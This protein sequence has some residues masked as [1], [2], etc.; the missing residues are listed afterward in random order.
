M[1][2]KPM[3]SYCG[4]MAGADW[5]FRHEPCSVAVELPV[6]LHIESVGDHVIFCSPCELDA[7]VVGFLFMAG[8][9]CCADDIVGLRERRHEKNIF[10][11]QLTQE[12]MEMIA[13][14][15]RRNRNDDTAQVFFTHYTPVGDALRIPAS[16]LID[17]A[18]QLREKQTIFAR[19]GGTHAAALF[20][21]DARILAFAED[22]SRQSALDKAVGNILLENGRTEG[23]G[24]MLSGRM[25]AE[26]V[27]KCA[28][29]KLEL[30]GAVSAPTSFALALAERCNITVCGFVRERRLTVFTHPRRIGECEPPV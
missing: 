23:L 5:N 12:R 8:M 2:W 21:S 17:V 20:R 16:Q 29:S 3:E 26:M 15:K 28:R 30:I 11:I 25:N 27:M 4:T 6:I 24:V 18:D 7:L 9:I 13:S 1:N 14:Q 10:D 19:T 22:I